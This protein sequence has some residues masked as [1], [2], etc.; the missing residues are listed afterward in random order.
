[1]GVYECNEWDVEGL[2]FK[3]MIGGGKTWYRVNPK[4]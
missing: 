4:F 2:N 3:L 1:M